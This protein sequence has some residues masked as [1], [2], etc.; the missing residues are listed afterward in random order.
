M[1]RGRVVLGELDDR[2]RMNPTTRGFAPLFVA[3]LAGVVVVLDQLSK[4]L[5]IRLLPAGQGW[6]DE[7]V[8]GLLSLVHV[9]NTGVAFGLFQGNSDILIVLSAIVVAV[10]VVYQ[11]RLAGRALLIRLAIGL[12]V[13]GAIGNVIDR[14][15]LGHVTDFVKVG[16][17][18][19]FNVAD[20]SIV[21]G[22]LLLAFELW[23][24]E[25]LRVADSDVGSLPETRADSSIEAG[26]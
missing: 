26:P 1:L 16:I 15:R 25:R 24:Q 22:V 12:Q 17:W 13:G 11:Q 21:V 9:H 23:R 8:F 14:V 6:P 18:P 19:V 3:G 5:V 10:L 7:P 20:S 4:A 2:L